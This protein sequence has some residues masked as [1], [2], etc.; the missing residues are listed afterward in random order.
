MI[1]ITPLSSSFFMPAEWESHKATW[2]AWPYDTTTFP[3][4]VEAVEK[5]FVRIIES[6]HQNEVVELLVLN[7][8]MKKHVALLLKDF[9]VKLNNVNFHLVNY[10]DVWMRDCGPVFVKGKKDNKI[11]WV[12]WIYNAYGEK[13]T[14]LL[15]DNEVPFQ[16]E[17][18]INLP[19]LDAGIVME[20]GAVD[21]NGSGSLITTEECLLNPNRNCKLNKKQIEDILKSFLGVQNIIWLKRGVVGDHT[22]GHVDEVARFISKDAAL[23]ASEDDKNDSNF[24]IL[25]ENFNILKNSKLE[26]GKSLNVVKLPLPHMNYDNGESAPVS[27]TNFYVANKVV[28]VPQFNHVND[29]KALDILQRAFPNRKTIGIDCSNLIYGGGTIHC[30]TQQQPLT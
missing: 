26:N 21:V 16:L 24:D 7:E 22:D 5:V 11:A 3:N 20:G 29:K 18:Y 25:N 15:K 8:A 17:N 2:L 13:F 4:R 9:N 30:V 10:A 14:D 27:Y 12:K 19:F 6:L 23:I 1:N 28:L